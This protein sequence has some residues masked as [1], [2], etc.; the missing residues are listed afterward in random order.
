M[1]GSG[2][3]SPPPPRSPAPASAGSAFQH[4]SWGR[5][6]STQL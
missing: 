2:W 1:I 3:H 6:P 5:L 4:L